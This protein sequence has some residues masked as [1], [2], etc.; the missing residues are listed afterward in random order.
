MFENIPKFPNSLHGMTIEGV[1]LIV[2]YP[3]VIECD[4]VFQ[5]MGARTPRIV[6]VTQNQELMFVEMIGNPEEFLFSRSP[7]FFYEVK[8]PIVIK[9]FTE[10]VSNIKVTSK[11]PPD[12]SKFTGPTLV[13]T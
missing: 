9:L 10:A 13:K 2:G 11:M 5:F 3:I 8:D 12:P 1:G 4:N 6:K 7:V